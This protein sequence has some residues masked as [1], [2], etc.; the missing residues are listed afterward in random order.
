MC[1]LLRVQTSFCG[2]TILFVDVTKGLLDLVPTGAL[3][4]TE[5]VSIQPRDLLSSGRKTTRSQRLTVTRS[6]IQWAF[7]EPHVCR[8]WCWV[9]GR[10]RR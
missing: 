2:V 4:L 10:T 9:V 8:A 3:P 5:A 6:F 1:R 7:T